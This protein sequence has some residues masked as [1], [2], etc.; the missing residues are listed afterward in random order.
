MRWAR[1]ALY[2]LLGT[3]AVLAICLAVI[4]NLD[5]GRFQGYLE[6][7]V[8]EAL[9]REFEI[10]GD[11]VVE[12]D[13][14]RIRIVASEVRVAGSDWGAA[15]DLARI[16]RLETQVDT[17]SLLNWPI[18]IESLNVERIRVDLEQ[19]GAGVGNWEFFG[20]E[21]EFIPEEDVESPGDLPLIVES[22]R[23]IDV[24]LA[25]NN[26]ERPR[27][28]RFTASQLTVDRDEA[29][30]LDLN[31]AALLNE[32]PIVF[33]AR[34]GQV[35]DLV[36][37][38]DVSVELSA[39]LGEIELNG[40]AT[41][42]SLLQPQRPTMQ[43]T[44]SGPNA[45]Y[46]TEMLEV[47][48]ITSGPLYLTAT[49]APLGDDMQLNL[50]GDYGEFTFDVSGQFKNLQ[51]LDEV[52]LR[53]A[54]S[55]PDAGAIGRL[56]GNPD[57]PPEPFSVVG[58]LTRAG[59][60]LD[61]EEVAIDIGKTNFVAKAHFPDLPRPTGA[62]GTLRISGP[63]FGLFSRLFGLPGR[64]TGPFTMDIDL[65]PQPDGSGALK[66][67]ASAKDLEFVIA[68]TVANTPDL[69]GTKFRVDFRGPDLRTVTDALGL[70]DAPSR[71]FELG[72]DLE[73]VAN[74]ISLR[75]GSIVV[76]NDRARFGG[77]V[78]NAPLEADTDLSFEVEGPNLSGTL[79]AF[80]IDAD[81]LP[82][83]RY[84]AGGRVERVED[85]FM[86]HDISAA[87]GDNL[88]YE[89]NVAGNV[90]DSP[91]LV[92]TRMQVL[93]RG[94]SLGALTDAAG[95]AGIPDLPF[96]VEASLERV[97]NGFA[98]ENGRARLGQDSVAVRGLVGEKPLERDT[99]LRFDI[100]VADLKKT[101][102]GFGV[103]ADALPPG[104]FVTGGEI[105]SRGSRF[106]LR[107]VN[108]SLAGARATISGQLGAMPTLEGTDITVEV[109]GDDLAS[110]LPEDENLAKLNKP[111]GVAARVQLNKGMLV[112][113]DAEVRLPGFDATAE[114]EVGLEPVMGRG[115]LAV[116]A[117]SPDLVPLMPA[118]YAVLQADKVPLRL[119]VGSVWD[120]NR[121]ALEELDLGLARGTLV[122]GGTIGAPPDFNGTD[123]TLDLNIAS[124]RTLSV[125][126]GRE[127]PDDS[128]QFKLRVAGSRGLMRSDHFAGGFG[129]SDIA[130]RFVLRGGDVPEIEV[131]LTSERLNLEPYL[132]DEADEAD[133]ADERDD[134]PP[135]T[136]ADGRVIPDIPIP[137]DA[138]KTIAA[139]VD[140][141]IKE[142][143][144]G[145]K[146]FT[147]IILTGSLTDGALAV[148][149][150]ALSNNKGGSLRGNFALRPAGETAALSLDVAGSGL[151]LGMPA[152]TTEELAAL[153]RYELD[154]V[155]VASGSTVRELAASLSGY[156]RLVGG[157]GRMRATALRFFTG[158]FLSEV[159][160]TVNPFTKSD[161]YTTFQCAV[162]LAEIENGK[163]TGQP[164]L[165]A[166]TERLRILA[167]AEIDLGTEKFGA[168][169]RTVPQKGL[170]L[171]VGDLVNPFVKLGGTFANPALALDPEG[172]LISGGTAVATAGISILAKRFKQRFIDDQDACGKALKEAEP[173]FVE[174]GRRYRPDD[175]SN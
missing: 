84:R 123:L 87:I 52:S 162:V 129:D 37:Y 41:I 145:P 35:A 98:I 160:G 119:K 58:R 50:N 164:I 85:Q 32:T 19:D 25:Y 75:D 92:G 170:G 163:V 38:R 118:E 68:G 136:K 90:T 153:P 70:A 104:K 147:D 109:K 157:E 61:V 105:R 26:P 34:A 138:M 23:I 60:I 24:A 27:P 21:E 13:L 4:L 67:A 132:P 78:G 158:D 9:D 82:S 45:E 36:R 86:L 169:I 77:L 126:A 46:L 135:P 2:S 15:P 111:F 10:E 66:L 54:T 31:L 49:I 102:A 107:G 93:A 69:S 16:G 141:D 1:I 103:D 113:K 152:A 116:E 165:V 101:L 131:G 56:A 79:A 143:D 39:S 94:K 48:Q 124:L 8:T 166:Q 29:D 99:D 44:V 127:L 149:R 11:L 89:L 168:T 3:V 137:M 100:D 97:D 121:W 142:I 174:L 40:K 33:D 140:I 65:T 71:P 74:G 53:V 17:L 117:S 18:R 28:L 171:S 43:L 172:A 150:F 30:Y 14:S 51:E 73:R 125:L 146:E 64:L 72:I 55:G 76:G 108:A 167:N 154:T 57:V 22:A 91:D 7:T 159:V 20:P 130:G 128:A 122:G 156:L 47:Q 139:T 6:E 59:P 151:I 42:D 12:I 88:E 175:A 112:L 133:A 173:S 114:L 63:E 95:I 110:L 134:A 62:E 155:L 144:L 80:G 120:Q 83:A 106:E 96:D 148:E 5:F 115:R 161:P 81:E